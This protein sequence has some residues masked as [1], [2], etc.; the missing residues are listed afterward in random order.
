MKEKKNHLREKSGDWLYS[1]LCGNVAYAERH[2]QC[3]CPL[4]F[5]VQSGQIERGRCKKGKLERS[6][7]RCF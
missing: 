1:V 7:N 6:L 4:S 5:A 2:G 3:S